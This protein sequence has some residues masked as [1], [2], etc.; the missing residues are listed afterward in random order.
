MSKQKSAEWARDNC[1]MLARRQIRRLQRELTENGGPGMTAVSVAIGTWEHILRICEKAGAQQHGVLREDVRELTKQEIIDEVTSHPRLGWREPL[2]AC[3]PSGTNPN[4]ELHR[5]RAP[6][7]GNAQA[8]DDLRADGGLPESQPI[9]A[10]TLNLRLQQLTDKATDILNTT[11][12]RYRTGL[13]DGLLEAVE[14][15]ERIEVP[16]SGELL[17]ALRGVVRV[18][19]RKTPEFDAARAAIANTEK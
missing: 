12:D 19:D 16:D 7:L 2:C 8:W 1:H 11:N 4:C 18:A 17:A 14:A 10:I 13:A 15:V 3:K 5:K 9:P 6:W